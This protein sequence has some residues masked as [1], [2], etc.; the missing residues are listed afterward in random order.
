M[1]TA[2]SSSDTTRILRDSSGRVGAGRVYGRVTAGEDGDFNRAQIQ[3]ESLR[4]SPVLTLHELIELTGET[5]LWDKPGGTP[6]PA[7]V[8]EILEAAWS[9]ALAGRKP[10]PVAPVPRL[11]TRPLTRVQQ[12]RRAVSLRIVYWPLEF[13]S[14]EL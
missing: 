5:D 7:E 4:L 8:A 3:W 1:A 11:P 14:T 6:I 9:E 13:G 12:S 10:I 2:C